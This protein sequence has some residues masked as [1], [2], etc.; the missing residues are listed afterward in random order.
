[1]VR[2]TLFI[3]VL[4]VAISFQLSS[5]MY[6][7]MFHGD[8]TYYGRTEGGHC[9]LKLPRPPM[10]NGF[11][12]VS[13]NTA[14][15]GNSL[16][17]GA[18]IEFTGTGKGSGANP[19]RGTQKGYIMDSCP[20]C[21]YGDL[22]IS[23]SGD[24]RWEVKWRFIDCP[25]NNVFFQLQGSHEWYK[26][27]QPRGS[28]KPVQKLMLNGKPGSRTADNFFEVHGYMTAPMTVTM[29][30]VGGETIT[31]KLGYLVG[32]GM[33]YPSSS[34]SSGKFGADSQEFQGSRSKP[35]KPK[36]KSNKKK[37]CVPNWRPCGGR[38]N[39]RR[40]NKCCGDFKCVIKRNNRGRYIGKRC[41]P[42]RRGKGG[43]RCVPK[44][45]ACSRGRNR[46]KTSKCCGDFTCQWAN[47][48][49]H[50]RHKICRPRRGH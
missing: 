33:V 15:Y 5:S 6:G 47:K 41:E 21:A 29:T 32:D 3:A 50:R 45:R 12:P 39:K 24:G 16:P 37:K 22:D 11:V 40:T 30:L 48:K 8:G 43:K 35:R 42:N 34:S 28:K 27:I 46:W 36:R 25:S 18:C 23:E 19:I 31:A 2:S 7:P 9:S 44:W 4:P 38:G 1:M 14:Q 10:Y 13:L 49:G 26:K 20:S 17:C